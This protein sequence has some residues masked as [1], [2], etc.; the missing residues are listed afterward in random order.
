MDFLE[1]REDV[2]AM[3]RQKPGQVTVLIGRELGR[4]ELDKTSLEVSRYQVN[5]QDAGA[6]AV[7]GPVRMD[8]PRVTAV[9]RYVS[10]Q[11]GQMLTVLMRDE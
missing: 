11:V 3:L 2:A 10:D 6:L 9:L 8:Y 1:R 4:A 7:L 5:G